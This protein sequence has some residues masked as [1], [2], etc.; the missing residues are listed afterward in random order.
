MP[1][2]ITSSLDRNSYL[3]GAEIFYEINDF[4]WNINPREVDQLF[5]VLNKDT[6][7]I[8]K[9]LSSPKGSIK[10]QDVLPIF[11][12]IDFDHR[13]ILEL[14]DG[15]E[16]VAWIFAFSES[17]DREVNFVPDSPHSF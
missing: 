6:G 1:E 12:D 8:E 10:K 13:Q 5:M 7:F 9:I 3:L 14:D 16:S 17:L 2:S 11:P 15:V 4:Q